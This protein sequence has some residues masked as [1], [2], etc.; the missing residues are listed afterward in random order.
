MDYLVVALVFLVIGTGGGWYLK[1]KFGP[2]AAADLQAVS[3]T[4]KKL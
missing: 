3:D 2:R 1:S 4:A